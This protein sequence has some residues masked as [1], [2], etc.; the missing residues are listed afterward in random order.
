M[1]KNFFYTIPSVFILKNKDVIA[2][3]DIPTKIQIYYDKNK[4]TSIFKNLYLPENRF[5]ISL[6]FFSTFII[7]PIMYRIFFGSLGFIISYQTFYNYGYTFSSLKTKHFHIHH[8]L[9]CS[10]ILISSSFVNIANPFIIGLCFGAIT[11]GIQHPD[12]NKIIIK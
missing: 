7:S 12:W 9:Y 6:L 3:S 10:I 5:V 4:Y 2:L 1:N 8:W 11:H